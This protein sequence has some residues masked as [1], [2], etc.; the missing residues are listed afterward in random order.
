M[1]VKDRGRGIDQEIRPMLFSKFATTSDG[2]TGLGLF[3][4]KWIIEAHDGKIWTENNSEGQKGAIFIFTLPIS[5]YN[6]R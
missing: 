2:G 1:S 6:T 5:E 3:I 4:S